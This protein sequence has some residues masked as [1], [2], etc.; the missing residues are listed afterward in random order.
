[1]LARRGFLPRSPS[2]LLLAACKG[3][4]RFAMSGC[5]CLLVLGQSAEST[6]GISSGCAEATNESPLGESVVDG[7]VTL[8]FNV[9]D[10]KWG[11]GG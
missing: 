10:G 11:I 8:N 6:P 2:P 9:Y 3:L 5:W 1:M 7:L 4:C